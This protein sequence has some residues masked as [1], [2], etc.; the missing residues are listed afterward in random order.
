MGSPKT[1]AGLRSAVLLLLLVVNLTNG[2]FGP[3]FSAGYGPVGT[4]RFGGH[5]SYGHGSYGHHSVG[6]GDTTPA[7]ATMVTLAMAM[8]TLVTD[9]AIAA[10]G[11]ATHQDSSM[12]GLSRIVVSATMAD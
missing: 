2:A 7:T 8:V 1:M 11:M 10:M 5:G 12:G 3:F 9:M 4:R 6:Y